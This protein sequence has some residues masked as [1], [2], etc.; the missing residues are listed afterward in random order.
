MRRVDVDTVTFDFGSWGLSEEQA[1]ALTGVAEALR[2]VIE[3]N[4]AEVFL[5]EGHTDAVG[6][7]ID[8]LTLSDRRAEAVATTL[9]EMYGVPAE[10]LTTEGYGEQYLKINTEEP[11]RENRRVTIRRI[12]PLLQDPARP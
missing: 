11:E 10:N 7:E 12:T 6:S 1:R 4:P 2:R 8:N 3:G 5:I 9:T